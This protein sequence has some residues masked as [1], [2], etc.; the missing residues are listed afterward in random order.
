MTLP[1]GLVEEFLPLP[2][3]EDARRHARVSD[4]ALSEA[5]QRRE[6]RAAS[7]RA[8]GVSEELIA[9]VLGPADDHIAALS[10]IAIRDAL[11]VDY[12]R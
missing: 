6:R 12:A 2:S 7:L 5:R 1:E 4:R 8:Q 11:T 10:W 9:E 3:H